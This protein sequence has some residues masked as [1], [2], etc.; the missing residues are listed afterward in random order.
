MSPV[1][2]E[3]EKE[4]LMENFGLKIRKHKNILAATPSPFLHRTFAPHCTKSKVFH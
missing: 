1:Q 2:F 4:Y 3:L